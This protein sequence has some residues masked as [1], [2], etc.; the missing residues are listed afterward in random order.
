MSSSPF[1]SLGIPRKN[2]PNFLGTH[3]LPPGNYPEVSYLRK[4]QTLVVLTVIK[5]IWY[6]VTIRGGISRKI[7]VI[8]ENILERVAMAPIRLLSLPGTVQQAAG[9]GA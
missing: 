5:R 8:P 3:S 7:G 9:K 1:S 2:V 4:M 6:K